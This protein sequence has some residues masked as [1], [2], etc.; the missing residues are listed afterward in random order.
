MHD[1]TKIKL[2]YNDSDDD[3]IVVLNDADLLE[4]YNNLFANK[5]IKFFVY[6]AGF[7]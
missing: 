3:E 7:I 4:A 1:K 2:K 6:Y 5:F